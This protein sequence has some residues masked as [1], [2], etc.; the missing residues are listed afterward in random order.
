MK[1]ALIFSVLILA[2][3]CTKKQATSSDTPSDLKQQALSATE[4]FSGHVQIE[5]GKKIY[6]QYCISCHNPDPTQVG[7][8]G[9]ALKGSSLDLLKAR[10]L[11]ST[12]PAG[13]RP[14]R[15]TKVMPSFPYLEKDIPS[16]NAFINK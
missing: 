16:L 8:V 1:R 7:S 14:Q 4:G 11:S 6:T 15:P 9:P 13:Y 12:Y 5:A 2:V 3:A 10:V